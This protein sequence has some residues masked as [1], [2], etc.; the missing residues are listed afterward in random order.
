MPARRFILRSLIYSQPQGPGCDEC[1]WPND[2]HPVSRRNCSPI[3]AE[4]SGGQRGSSEFDLAAQKNK[5][6]P[7]WAK[8]APLIGPRSSRVTTAPCYPQT[9][10]CPPNCACLVCTKPQL[11][12]P[13]EA[14]KIAAKTL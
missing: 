6:Q 5:K 13:K 9:R 2:S 11:E 4:S 1:S 14:K 12:G 10:P 3:A 7:C 8:T